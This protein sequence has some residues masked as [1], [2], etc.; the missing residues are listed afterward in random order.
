[1]QLRKSRLFTMMNT[2]EED[3]PSETK[4][5]NSSQIQ[6]FISKV[7]GTVT[8]VLRVFSTEGRAVSVFEFELQ[9]PYPFFGFG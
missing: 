8:K 2:A 5:E 3:E 6:S 9:L 4:T 7:N 1:M